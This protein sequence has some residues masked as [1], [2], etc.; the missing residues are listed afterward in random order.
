MLYLQVI[1]ERKTLAVRRAQC[2]FLLQ[3]CSAASE[4]A[5]SW[6]YLAKGILSWVLLLPIGMNQGFPR[7]NQGFPRTCVL[8]DSIEQAKKFS[9]TSRS[10]RTTPTSTFGSGRFP[11]DMLWMFFHLSPE[12]LLAHRTPISMRCAHAWPWESTV[13]V[14]GHSEIAEDVVWDL[15]FPVLCLFAGSQ[16]P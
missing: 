1:W 12:V 7:M 16:Y 15:H 5:Y 11:S 2:P 14:S 4:A 6:G 13:W 3:L 8:I 9:C 10:E